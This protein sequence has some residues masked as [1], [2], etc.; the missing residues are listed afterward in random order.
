MLIEIVLELIKATAMTDMSDI[1]DFEKYPLDRP[2][3]SEWSALV[4]DC[5]AKLAKDGLFNLAGFVKPDAVVEAVEELTP[6]MASSSFT[7]EREHNIYFDDVLKGLPADHAV[8]KRFRTSNRTI[9]ADQIGQAVVI[10]LY[11]WPPFA[12]FLSA[13]MG[14]EKLWTMEDPLARVNV[15]AYHEG[16]ELNWHFDRSEFTTTLLLQ[17]PMAGGQLEY[18]KDLRSA[19]NPNYGGIA[20]LLSGEEPTVRLTLEPG[21]LNIFRGVNTPH[22]VTEVKGDR[23]RG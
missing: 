3:S 16:Q 7:H 2:G 23:D 14:K 12:E 8:L 22:R 6:V 21:T 11:E 13:V 18:V 19:D 1:L 5:K 15:M 9:C 17:T 4:S 20:K 10:R